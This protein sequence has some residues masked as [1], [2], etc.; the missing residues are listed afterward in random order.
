MA[1]KDSNDKSCQRERRRH[2]GF[3][4]RA[5]QLL[6]IRSNFP[7][8]EIYGYDWQQGRCIYVQREREVQEVYTSYLIIST[9]CFMSR[10]Y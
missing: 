7:F 8:S 3:G 10:T 2:E 4:R 6:A 5:V 1:S 9:I